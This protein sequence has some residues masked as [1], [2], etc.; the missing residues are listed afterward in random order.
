MCSVKK[1]QSTVHLFLFLPK[2]IVEHGRDVS[3]YYSPHIEIIV[4]IND[5]MNMRNLISYNNQLFS[6]ISWQARDSE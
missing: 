2:L 1:V 3:T 4:Q 5:I 6:S